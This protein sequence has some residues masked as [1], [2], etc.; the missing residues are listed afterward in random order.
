[1]ITENTHSENNDWQKP[2]GEQSS[3]SET[4]GQPLTEGAPPNAGEQSSDVE[5]L[6]QE[7]LYATAATDAMPTVDEGQNEPFAALAFDDQKAQPDAFAQTTTTSDVEQFAPLDDATPS[8]DEAIRPFTDFIE[9]FRQTEERFSSLLH[10]S[11]TSAITFT[12]GSELIQEPVVLAEISAEDL[13][14]VID[15]AQTETDQLST[16]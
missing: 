16:N 10:E 9:E 8:N 14:Q 7:T 12:P 15:T 11:E 1:M 5:T 6:A 4:S 13:A 2:G 3:A